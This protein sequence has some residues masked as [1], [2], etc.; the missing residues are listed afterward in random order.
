MP[1]AY[2]SL[3]AKTFLFGIL[4]NVF[5]VTTGHLIYSYLHIDPLLKNLTRIFNGMNFARNVVPSI[6]KCDVQIN[7]MSICCALKQDTLSALASIDVYEY[8]WEHH[9]MVFC[10]MVMSS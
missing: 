9:D 5:F 3:N 10:S 8:R 2:F 7:T 6:R 1:F 4:S